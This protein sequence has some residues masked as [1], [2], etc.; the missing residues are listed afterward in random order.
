M[1]LLVR[2]ARSQAGRMAGGDESPMNPKAIALFSGVDGRPIL[3]RSDAGSCIN[4]PPGIA[5]MARELIHE[6]RPVLYR[7]MPG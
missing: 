5:R 3:E 2:V 6:G 7:L 1:I 4:Y